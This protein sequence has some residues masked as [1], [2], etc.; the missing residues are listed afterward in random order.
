M[1]KQAGSE[2]VSLGSHPDRGGSQQTQP[3]TPTSTV[4]AFWLP[5]LQPRLPGP[6]PEASSLR[7]LAIS[8]SV[9]VV[10][11]RQKSAFLPCSSSMYTWRREVQGASMAKGGPGGLGVSKAGGRAVPGCL[12][13]GPP[14]RLR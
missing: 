11:S 6:L 7:S 9:M 14:C 12:P 13:A 2:P 4:G 10:M 1:G 8:S 5:W 3:G